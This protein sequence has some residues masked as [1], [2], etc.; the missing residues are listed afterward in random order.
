MKSRQIVYI[1]FNLQERER[2]NGKERKK[3]KI[4]IVKR[5]SFYEFD[6]VGSAENDDYT[7]LLYDTAS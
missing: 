1:T 5:I 7:I 3:R 6:H 4:Y 2:N